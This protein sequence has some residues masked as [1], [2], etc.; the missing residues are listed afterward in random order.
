MVRTFLKIP[1]NHE[2]NYPRHGYSEAAL[3]DHE[4]NYP[5]HGYSEAALNFR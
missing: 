2:Y 5:R 1:G 4:Y 3:G